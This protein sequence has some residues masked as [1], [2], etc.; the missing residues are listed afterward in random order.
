MTTTRSL[1]QSLETLLSALLDTGIA[2]E[3]RPVTITGDRVT[4]Q[5][6]PSINPFLGVRGHATV[7]QY[8]GWLAGKEFSAVLFDGSLIQI[9]CQVSDRSVS[10][11]RLAHIPCPYDLDQELLG[12]GFSVE[13]VV[14]LYQ[15]SPEESVVLRSPLRF[16]Y[17]PES[18]RPG[19]PA[20]HFTINSPDCRIACV[21]PIHP[22]RFI[23]FILGQ[24]YPEHHSAHAHE[25]IG[26]G[27]HLGPPDISDDDR[28]RLHINWASQKAVTP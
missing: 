28:E 25:F 5:P 4:W 26:V 22:A 24:F 19:H 3:T 12:E 16:D 14:R 2:I 23:D 21:A 9:S 15:E 10:G 8:L 6:L 7:E 20:A 11:H 13:D 18:A 17:D 1:A 27:S